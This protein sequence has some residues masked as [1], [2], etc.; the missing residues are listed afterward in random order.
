MTLGGRRVAAHRPRM[1][2]AGDE[3]ELPTRSDEYFADWNPLTRAVIDRMLRASQCA[4]VRDRRRGSTIPT[5]G[6]VPFRAL[7][8]SR[9]TNLVGSETRSWQLVP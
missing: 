7:I 6:R 8:A 1:R 3:R 2:T 4:R 5:S 9:L